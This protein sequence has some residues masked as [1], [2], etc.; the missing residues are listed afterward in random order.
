MGNE[1]SDRID[2]REIRQALDRI[3][4]RVR[5]LESQNS[6]EYATPNELAVIL[7]TSPN[8]VYR[9]VRN[10]E[11]KAQKLGRSYRI[12]MHQF[13]QSESR[14]DDLKHLIFED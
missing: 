14:F 10:G 7:K 3:E 13:C 11:I 1:T 2:M 5:K 4:Q 9:K 12:P 8:N 6:S